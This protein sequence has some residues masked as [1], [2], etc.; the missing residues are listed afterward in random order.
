LFVQLDTSCQALSPVRST[1]GIVDIVRFG[2]KTALARDSIVKG[3]RGRADAGTGLQRLHA[4]KFEHGA[5]VSVISGVCTAL[6]AIFEREVG[7]QW[8][9]VLLRLLGRDAAVCVPSG[10]IC[11]RVASEQR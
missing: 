4:H 3:P 2:S 6:D 7:E 10:F 11:P 1:V 9:V 8:V 5:A